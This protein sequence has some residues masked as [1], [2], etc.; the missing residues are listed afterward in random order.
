MPKDATAPETGAV[1]HQRPIAVAGA[2]TMLCVTASFADLVREI[3]GDHAD[4]FTLIPPGADPLTYEP[5]PSDIAKIAAADIIF[6]NDTKPGVEGSILDVIESNK[7][8]NTKVIPFMPNVR[9]PR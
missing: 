1:F 7:G 2:S 9:S 6:V 8:E 4:V 5:T 3:A